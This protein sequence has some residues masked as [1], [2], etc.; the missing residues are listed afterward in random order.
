MRS[1][2]VRALSR[3]SERGVT[4][5]LVE[6]VNRGIDWPA[7]LA[8]LLGDPGRARPVQLTGDE[9]YSLYALGD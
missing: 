5:V 1:D 4:H 8:H 6:N 3:L 2:H 9:R 7:P